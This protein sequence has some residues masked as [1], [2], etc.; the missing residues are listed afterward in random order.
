[1]ISI[2]ISKSGLPL[3]RGEEIFH[4]YKIVVKVFFFFFIIFYFSDKLTETVLNKIM[5]K[6]WK[7]RKEGLEE[8]SVF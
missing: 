2:N 4:H 6:N 1:V 7:I 5:D 3:L 8:V